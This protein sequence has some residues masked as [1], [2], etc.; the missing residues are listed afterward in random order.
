MAAVAGIYSVDPNV[1]TPE[2]VLE[3]LFAAPGKPRPKDPKRPKPKDKRLRACL[4]HVDFQ[5]ENNDGTTAM[6][7]WLADQTKSRNPDG[8]KNV[9]PLTAG[10]PQ[11][12]SGRDVF[13]GGVPMVDI[14][15]LLHA[16]PRIW[17]MSRLF[18][19]DDASRKAFV[20][21]RVGRILRGQVL[22]VGQGLRSMATPRGLKRK[23]REEV[24]KVCAYFERNASRMRHDEYLAKGC[25]IASG[26]IEDACRHV[27]KDRMERTGMGRRGVIKHRDVLPEG[28]GQPVTPS[29]DS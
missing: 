7:V 14:L 17:A 28:S 3:S 11:L 5:G 18:C 20:K 12:W 29:V 23:R 6:F 16:T 9:I 19:Q 13:E 25:L 21:Q 27:V 2:Q 4:P 8:I 10:E 1:R 26:V 24:D 15:D 22:S